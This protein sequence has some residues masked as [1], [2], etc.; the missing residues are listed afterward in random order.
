MIPGRL[1]KSPIVAFIFLVGLS[2]GALANTTLWGMGVKSCFTFNHAFEDWQQ[3]KPFGVENYP[4]YR[5]WIMGL[6]SGLSA[7]TGLDV[8]HGSDP[9][10][11][12]RAIYKICRDQPGIDF[13]NA[14]MTLFGRMAIPGEESATFNRPPA[15]PQPSDR[16]G[17][18]NPWPP[19]ATSI[20]LQPTPVGESGQSRAQPPQSA[21]TARPEA[22][23]VTEQKR[24]KG[25]RHPRISEP[26]DELPMRRELGGDPPA[27]EPRPGPSDLGSPAAP[28][29]SIAVTAP[30]EQP[31]AKAPAPIVTPKATTA[32]K[33]KP[34]PQTENTTIT[35]VEE[36]RFLVEELPGIGVPAA[37]ARDPS[38]E[39]GDSKACNDGSSIASNK[40][41]G[42]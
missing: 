40:S 22:R 25:E 8:L 2:G 16:A 14:A 39:A 24:R 7:S 29:P 33:P 12:L 41:C 3:E 17:L 4:F 20:P 10:K 19:T 30:L 11:A 27:P 38:S 28:A 34:V 36:P 13:F 1:P 23:V 26:P 37:K 5:E 9:D 18:Q 42:D 31:P 32:P 21:P 15:T 6:A 35:I